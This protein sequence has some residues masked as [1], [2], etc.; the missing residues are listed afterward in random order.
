MTSAERTEK[1]L[2]LRLQG[3]AFGWIG[4][5]VGVSKSRAHKVVKDWMD[6]AAAEAAAL[7][8]KIR[9]LELARLEQMQAGLWE[10]ATTGNARAV[11]SMLRLMERRAKLMGLDA[12]TKIAPTKPNGEA[13]D[14]APDGRELAEIVAFLDARAALPAPGAD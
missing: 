4:R 2:K 7:G 1:I 11:D 12:P 10:K 3:H 5:E 14:D 8:D 13:L 6:Q 9:H